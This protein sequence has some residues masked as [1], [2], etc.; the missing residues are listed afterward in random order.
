MRKG[1]AYAEGAYNDV[2]PAL[3]PALQDHYRI[4]PSPGGP[5]EQYGMQCMF[6]T[7]YWITLGSYAVQKKDRIRIY[8]KIHILDDCIQ[9]LDRV[10]NSW[11]MDDSGEPSQHP[12]GKAHLLTCEWKLTRPKLQPAI[13]SMYSKTNAMTQVCACVFFFI[14]RWRKT[15]LWLGLACRIWTAWGSGTSFPVR[16][17]DGLRRRSSG[18]AHRRGTRWSLRGGG[19]FT[20][21]SRTSSGTWYGQPFGRWSEIYALE[22][23]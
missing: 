23:S 18:I 17:C 2:D 21:P 11:N 9:H 6:Q 14:C 7:F 10:S 15:A 1:P 8:I 5:G 22:R 20:A 12:N 4:T 16:R 19:S 3:N 13:F